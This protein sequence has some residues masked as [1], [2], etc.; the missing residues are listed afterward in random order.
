MSII[1]SA[2]SDKVLVVANR[3]ERFCGCTDFGGPARFGV[4]FLFGCSADFDGH[5][6]FDISLSFG[7][8]TRLDVLIFSCVDIGFGRMTGYGFSCN[9]RSLYNAVGIFRR[10]SLYFNAAARSPVNQSH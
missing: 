3:L 10:L 4:I 8:T 5:V 2:T 9:L 1:I 6:R 7:L